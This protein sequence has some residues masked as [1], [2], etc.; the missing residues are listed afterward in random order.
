MKT[1]GT[2]KKDDEKRYISIPKQS[3]RDHIG[4]IDQEGKR[5]F[6]YPR[7][8]S[9]RYTNY[10]RYSSYLLLLVLFITPLIYIDGRPFMMFNVLE[11]KFILFGQIFWPEDFFLAVLAMIIGVLFI[12]VF[13]VAFGRLF[14]GWICPQ[15]IFM[16]HVFRRI[17]Y[18]IDGDR[19]QQMRL[20]NMP[21]SFEK[22][23]KRILKNGLFFAI[24]FGVANIFM[25]YL[26]SRD[27]WWQIVSDDPANHLG[28]LSSILIFSGV[29]FFV[30][31]WFREQVCLIVCPYGRLQSV[32]LDRHSIVIAYDYVRGELRSKFR[33][34]EDRTAAGKGDC[35]DCNQCVEVCPTGIDIRNGTQLEC[36]NCTACMDA[37]DH[38]MDKIDRPRGLIRYDSEE[39][40]AENQKRVLT[41]RVIA[42]A[43]VLAVLIGCM[44]F[45]L[46]SRTEVEAIILRMPGQ[47]YQ[48]VDAETLSNVY[49]YKMI[50]KTPLA[51][52]LNIRLL[53]P[54]GSLQLV[55]ADPIAVAPGALSEGAFIIQLKKDKLLGRN[56]HVKIGIYKESVLIDQITTYFN[57]PIIRN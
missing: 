7:K 48:Q 45:L 54:E 20:A 42:Y 11:R 38:I 41:T 40:I 35:I 10:R 8:T 5:K 31:S 27:A 14:C 32:L 13:T 52:E 12:A 18:W 51:L 47:L 1:D 43:A 2:G 57:G 25:M 50:N 9:G 46:A 16:E 36:I 23:W 30:F 28:G 26:I 6:L 39:N 49:N 34:G 19:N 21:W 24:S 4:T 53:K 44:S 55:G 3:F 37:C 22:L 56:T 33:K 15:T 29:F 17:E